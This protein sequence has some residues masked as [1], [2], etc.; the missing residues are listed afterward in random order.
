MAHLVS[1]AD[2]ARMLGVSRAAV[3]KR[4]AK[5]WA[6]A[7]EGDRVDTDHAAIQEAA[8]RRGVKLPKPDRSPTKVAKKTTSAPAEPTAAPK[9]FKSRGPKPTRVLPADLDPLPDQPDNEGSIEDLDDLG[10]LTQPLLDRFKSAPAA[11]EWAKFENIRETTLGRKLANAQARGAV[12]PR[13]WVRVHLIGLVDGMTNRLI[14][15]TP[16]TL[17]RQM[18]AMARAGTPVEEAELMTR[19]LLSKQLAGV[20]SKIEKLV[21]NG[22][23]RDNGG[24]SDLLRGNDRVDHDGAGND[25][26]VPVGGKL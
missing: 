1:R 17:C 22:I 7:C 18:Y 26:S 23:D 11:R 20:K 24:R 21:R 25:E 15:D 2:L 4:C 6:E 8:A 12:F 13:E 16:K 10:R 3:T 5:S 9:P 14:A 19:K